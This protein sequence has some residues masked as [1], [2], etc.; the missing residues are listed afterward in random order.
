MCSPL[1]DA[2]LDRL[3][4]RKIY[5]RLLLLFFGSARS[6]ALTDCLELSGITMSF[7]SRISQGILHLYSMFILFIYIILEHIY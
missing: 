6:L 4:L 1:S 2:G 5:I 7:L 3:S